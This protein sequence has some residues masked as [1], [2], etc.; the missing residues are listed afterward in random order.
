MNTTTF[1]T[2]YM[3]A[4]TDLMD[5]IASANPS[6][7]FDK[8]RR[9]ADRAALAA[10]NIVEESLAGSLLNTIESARRSVVI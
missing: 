9:N 8:A 4:T 1:A 10:G 2:A 7:R 3:R 6:V 5:A